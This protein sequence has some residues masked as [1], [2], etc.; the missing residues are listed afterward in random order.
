MNNSTQSNK[1]LNKNIEKYI[2]NKCRNLSI[3]EDN[4]FFIFLKNLNYYKNHNIYVN[5]GLF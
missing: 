3:K 5:H 2:S 4:D 1:G